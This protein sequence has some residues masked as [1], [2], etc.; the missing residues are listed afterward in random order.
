MRRLPIT[1]HRT[2]T[3][4]NTERPI[5]LRNSATSNAPGRQ[6]EHSRDGRVQTITQEHP[7]QERRCDRQQRHVL[8][9]VPRGVAIQH[10]S[11]RPEPVEG[12]TMNGFIDFANT[13]L[14]GLP[15]TTRSLPRKSG[16]P[17]RPVPPPAAQSR[18]CAC[19]AT[20]PG[21]TFFDPNQT[22]TNMAATSSIHSHSSMPL[23]RRWFQT[24]KIRNIAA[25]KMM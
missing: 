25:M 8:E 10:N 24:W 21:R 6:E 11:V 3:A 23:V 22:P 18:P 4:G 14:E 5:R 2:R 20:G 15:R 13:L 16:T 19:V 17:L 9:G 7:E 12:L 1:T